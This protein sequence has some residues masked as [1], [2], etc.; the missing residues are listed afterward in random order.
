MARIRSLKPEMW[1]SESVGR[2]SRDARLLLVSLITQVDDDGR[3]RASSRGLASLIYPFDADAV[4]LI[5]GWLAELQAEGMFIRYM[6]DGSTYGHL[7][8]FKQHQKIDHPTA[9][10][11]PAFTEVLANPRESSRILAPDQGSG[12]DRDRDRIGSGSGGE[13]EGHQQKRFIPPTASEVAAYCAERKNGIDG[14]RFVNHYEA[15]GWKIGKSKM[16]SWQAAVRTWEKS[17]AELAPSRAPFHPTPEQCALF[18][19]LT[20]EEAHGT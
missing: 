1:S 10:K 3:I 15:K 16:K 17:T 7:P 11:L 12:V 8:K 14:Q 20:A 2:L 19:S 4:D 9:S 5:D 6:A 18:D 13:S